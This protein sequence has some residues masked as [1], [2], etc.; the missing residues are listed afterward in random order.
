MRKCKRCRTG[1][2]V[3][4][5]GHV[6]QRCTAATEAASRVRAR[7][8]RIGPLTRRAVYARDGGACVYCGR[9]ERDFP[10]PNWDRRARMEYDHVLPVRAGGSGR[11]DNVVLSCRACNRAKLVRQMATFRVTLGLFLAETD[12]SV[13]AAWQGVIA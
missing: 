9:G 7:Y 12:P 4:L 10:R 6:C 1:D 3:L 11:I 5:T 2:V 13:R 8:S